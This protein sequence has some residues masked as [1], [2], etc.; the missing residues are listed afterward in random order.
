MFL[1]SVASE[2]LDTDQLCVYRG[3][4]ERSGMGIPWSG[5]ANCFT[6]VSSVCFVKFDVVVAIRQRYH[7]HQ[8]EVQQDPLNSNYVCRPNL[9][10]INYQTLSKLATSSRLAFAQLIVVSECRFILSPLNR[11][12]ISCLGSS[13]LNPPQ[14]STTSPPT[15]AP[16]PQPST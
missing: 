4:F 8:D 14:W 5:L 7:R 13:T 3:E 12:Q 10:F 1:H 15:S 16:R 6:C 9:G 11:M 2:R